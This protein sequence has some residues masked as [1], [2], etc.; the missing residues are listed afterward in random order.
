[1]M[2]SY[3]AARAT[4]LTL[5]SALVVAGLGVVVASSGCSD[6]GLSGV[7]GEADGQVEVTIHGMVQARGEAVADATVCSH[8][9]PSAQC[10]TTDGEGRFSMTAR[11]AQP[12]EESPRMVALT[13]DADGFAPILYPQSVRMDGEQAAEMY[14]DVRMVSELEVGLQALAAG[15][16]LRDD[17]AHLAVKVSSTT[18]AASARVWEGLHGYETTPTGDPSTYTDEGGVLDPERSS[19]SSDGGFVITNMEPGMAEVGITRRQG[20]ARCAMVQGFG[21]T[22]E[23]RFA[24]EMVP[25][26]I[27]YARA[28]CYD[29]P[30]KG[31]AADLSGDPSDLTVYERPTLGEPGMSSDS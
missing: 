17:R 23:N 3:P 15:I 9:T 29:V 16:D 13:F 7:E 6:T 1:M 20:K 24:M 21:S 2:T 8:F 14:V 31:P 27:T 18:I 4:K 22:G 25:G 19:T 10:A 12:S 30:P 28:V 11:S 26:R 5:R